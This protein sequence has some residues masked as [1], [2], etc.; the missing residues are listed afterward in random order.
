MEIIM[1]VS[2][3]DIIKAMKNGF[4]VE[5]EDTRRDYASYRGQGNF[6]ERVIYFF[7]VQDNNVIEKIL[8]KEYNQ[9]WYSTECGS[10]SDNIDFI[11]KNHTFNYRLP[12][13]YGSQYYKHWCDSTGYFA[14]VRLRGKTRNVPL[15]FIENLLAIDKEYNDKL[16]Y[17]VEFGL[18]TTNHAENIEAYKKNVCLKVCESVFK[19][20]DFLVNFCTSHTIP[21]MQPVPDNETEYCSLFHLNGQYMIGKGF[22]NSLVKPQHLRWKKV[23]DVYVTGKEIDVIDNVDWEILN[24]I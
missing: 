7:K 6:N 8:I 18:F 16:N 23:C 17:K 3:T 5:L 4:Y 19:E 9:S 22:W 2:Y 14:E 12:Y 13:F 21:G 20:Q 24:R 11:N 15:S 1:K 10:Y